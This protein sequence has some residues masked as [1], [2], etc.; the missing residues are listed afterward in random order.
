MATG[1][2]ADLSILQKLQLIGNKDARV[3]ANRAG[4][5]V[6]NGIVTDASQALPKHYRVKSTAVKKHA[7][8]TKMTVGSLNGKVVFLHDHGLPLFL[9]GPRPKKPA[10]GAGSRKTKKG[11]VIKSIAGGVSIEVLKGQRKKAKDTFVVRMESGHTAI[12]KRNP[13][14][15]GTTSDYPTH[16]S[17][18]VIE[19]AYGPSISQ[20]IDNVKISVEI[21]KGM[22]ARFNKEML[23][24]IGRALEKRGLIFA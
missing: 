15:K 14:K 8:K 9:F 5:R 24:E 22:H 12:V 4:N 6:V 17:H 21:K 7:K 1:V 3:A 19:E 11:T 10:T 18:M 20:M 2:T 13:D 16:P 23:H